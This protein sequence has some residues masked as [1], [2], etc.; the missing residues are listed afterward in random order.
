MLKTQGASSL[1]ASKLTNLQTG[2][3]KVFKA[4]ELGI[5]TNTS[6]NGYQYITA[7]QLELER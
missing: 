5:G 2:D 3:S 7:E 4:D 1:F 6:K